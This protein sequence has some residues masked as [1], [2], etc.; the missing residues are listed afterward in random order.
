VGIFYVVSDTNSDA[1][2]YILVKIGLFDYNSDDFDRYLFS[3]NNLKIG[4]FTCEISICH[5]IS[6]I[7]K[8]P[9]AL[10]P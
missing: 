10:Y 9:L 4:A 5:L 6:S 7:L 8:M 2:L 1:S 3:P